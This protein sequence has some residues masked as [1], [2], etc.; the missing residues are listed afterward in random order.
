M[1][2]LWI[3]YLPLVHRRADI[4]RAFFHLT[5]VKKQFISWRLCQ[6]TTWV[7]DQFLHPLRHDLKVGY[8]MRPSCWNTVIKQLGSQK[9]PGDTWGLSRLFLRVLHLQALGALKA[10][11]CMVWKEKVGTSAWKKTDLSLYCLYLLPSFVFWLFWQHCLPVLW[12]F[13]SDS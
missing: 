13:S 8:R 9:S 5:N 2:R 11:C 3:V 4:A 7:W 10:W 6:E 12:S 1:A